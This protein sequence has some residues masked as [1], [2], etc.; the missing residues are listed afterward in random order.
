MSFIPENQLQHNKL[1][2]L[3]KTRVKSQLIYCATLFA[4]LGALVSL[5]FL[6]VTISV[7]TEGTIQGTTEIVELLAP[8]NGRLL[9]VNIKDNQLVRKGVS[10]FSIDAFLPKQ[11]E[12][13]LTKKIKELNILLSDIKQL[14]NFVI[15]PQLQSDLYKSSWQQ[16]QI[17]FK[18]SDQIVNQSLLIYQRHL[19]LFEKKVITP[20]EF[21]QHR[22]DLEQA[23]ADQQLVIKNFKTKWQTDANLY[24]NE[25]GNLINQKILLTEQAK[26][27]T[28][29]ASLDGFI[30]NL[31]GLQVGNSVFANQKLGEISPQTSLQANCYVSPSSIGLIRKGQSVRFAID[32]FNHNQ[33]G[34]VNGK[35][36]TI[37]DDV[38]ISSKGS[39]F[40]VKCQLANNYLQLKNGYK[41]QLKKGMTFKASFILTDRSMYQLLHDK[42]VDWLN[43]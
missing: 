30:Q 11:Q 3:N 39:F 34:I 38:I 26:D 40:K 23:K 42:V 16:Y 25:L 4:V 22:F 1:V 28:M 21:E 10:L 14:L 32:A 31:T 20:S 7:K 2:Y 18:K 37:S 36:I 27:Y 33:W 12:K 19:V 24:Q 13:Y 43:P 35:V 29:L 17:Q 41:G 8:V 15:N 6:Y 9:A 5:P